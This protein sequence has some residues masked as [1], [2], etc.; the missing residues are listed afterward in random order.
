MVERTRNEDCGFTLIELVVAMFVVVLVMSAVV[1]AFIAG[2]DVLGVSSTRL[3]Q[4][5]DRQLIEIWLPQDVQS[6]QTVTVKKTILGM[7]VKAQLATTK[8][9]SSV[10]VLT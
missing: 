6:A 10:L 1:S 4:A 8:T 5:D 9:V 2:S 7:C 3:A